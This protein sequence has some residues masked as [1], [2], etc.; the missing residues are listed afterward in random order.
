[1]LAPAQEAYAARYEESRAATEHTIDGT[2]CVDDMVPEAGHVA[3]WWFG[4]KSPA[5]WSQLN[6]R[7]GLICMASVFDPECP[8]PAAP[9]CLSLAGLAERAEYV[10]GTA[11]GAAEKAP[12]AAATTAAGAQAGVQTAVQGVRSAAA[13]TAEATREAAEVGA[14]DGRCLALGGWKGRAR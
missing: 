5:W 7:R 9:C 12:A 4:V 10:A 1:M 6:L 2:P 14:A 8:A 13:D 3:Y 11:V